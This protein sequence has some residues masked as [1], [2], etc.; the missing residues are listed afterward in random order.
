MHRT[1]AFKT[2]GG[3]YLLALHYL[4]ARSISVHAGRVLRVLRQ[5]DFKGHPMKSFLAALTVAAGFG[6]VAMPSS[7]APFAPSGIE[8]LPGVEHVQWDEGRCRRL[9]RQCVNKDARGERGEGNCRRYRRECGR[10][11]R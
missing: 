6:F 11:W 4:R 7:A 9:R 5:P 2:V 1:P 3:T 8:L 10:W